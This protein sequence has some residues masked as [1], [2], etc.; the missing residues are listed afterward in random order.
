MSLVCAAE[1]SGD[2]GL[3]VLDEDVKEQILDAIKDGPGA[4]YDVQRQIPAV[5]WTGCKLC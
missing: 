2:N 1:E 3:V 5:R 4:D